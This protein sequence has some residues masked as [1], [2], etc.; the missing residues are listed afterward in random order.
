MKWRRTKSV[1][2]N[3]AETIP[4]P[5]DHAYDAYSLFT[6]QHATV[7]TKI[8]IVQLSKT[9]KSSAEKAAINTLALLTIK[10]VFTLFIFMFYMAMRAC[11]YYLEAVGAF[12][13]RLEMSYNK[14]GNWSM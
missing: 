5:N 13:Q 7:K 9:W 3:I 4:T 6:V 11:L 12:Y 2:T 10:N 8:D 14:R 1:G